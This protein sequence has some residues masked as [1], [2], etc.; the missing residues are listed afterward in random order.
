MKRA[1]KWKSFNMLD[2]YLASENPNAAYRI[3]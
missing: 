1:K 3:V 2:V